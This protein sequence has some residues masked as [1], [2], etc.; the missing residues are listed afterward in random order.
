MEEFPVERNTK[1]G[2]HCTPVMHTRHRSLLGQINWLQRR[3]QFQCCY[4]FSRCASKA[5]SPTIGDPNALNKLARAQVAACETSILKS[6]F[7]Y[8]IP[9]FDDWSR[10]SARN[11]L[12]LELS[13]WFDISV[14]VANIHMRT[15]AKNLARTI[16]LPEQKKTIHMSSMSR[17]GACSRN[18]HYLAHIPTQNCLAD[19]LTKA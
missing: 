10:D 4:K 3:T 7:P 14:E 1:E 6:S 17:K 5:A 11:K 12:R 9:S 18:I 2:L 19:W 8:V 13:R 16:H 15:D